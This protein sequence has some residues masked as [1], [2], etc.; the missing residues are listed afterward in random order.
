MFTGGRRPGTALLALTAR[1]RTPRLRSTSCPLRRS[2]ATAVN[3]MRV[4][5]IRMSSR[6]ALMLC[7]K[8]SAET[9][10]VLAT[11]NE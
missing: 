3:G 10:D 1:R 2:A 6:S 8:Y 7:S 5:S 4:S 11:E 9:Q